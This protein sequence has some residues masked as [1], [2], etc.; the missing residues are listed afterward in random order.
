[1]PY[2]DVNTKIGVGGVG[3]GGGRGGPDDRGLIFSRF[4]PVLDHFPLE[5]FLFL[6]NL[7]LRRKTILKVRGVIFS[8]ILPWNNR[9]EVRLIRPN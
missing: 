2:Q 6:Q 9:T 4:P 5:M 7:C 3:K 1:M 8:L